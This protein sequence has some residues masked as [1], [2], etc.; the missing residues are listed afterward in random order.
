MYSNVVHFI[1]TIYRECVSFLGKG[2]N[3]GNCVGNCF[4]LFEGNGEE[5]G[6]NGDQGM[7]LY[8]YLPMLFIHAAAVASVILEPECRSKV[9]CA[10]Q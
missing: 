9:S 2:N 6:I 3:K 8:S 5:N 7:H 4:D 10:I 1:S